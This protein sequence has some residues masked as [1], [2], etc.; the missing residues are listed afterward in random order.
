LEWLLFPFIVTE[1][2]AE[3]SSLW[4]FGAGGTPFQALLAFRI[5]TEK[6]GA[7]LLG[8]HLCVPW[9]ISHVDFNILGLFCTFIVLIICQGEFPFWYSLFGVLYASCTLI[10]IS[11]FRE[12]FMILLKIFSV[13]STWVS[14]FSHIPIDVR[15]GILTEFQISWM[16]CI[17]KFLEL[18]FSLI[19]V[20]SFSVVSSESVILFSIPMFC[21]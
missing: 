2:F 11:F 1:S 3:Y 5:P 10:G 21:C 4:S 14:S 6:S 13:F 7:V 18:T 20:S 16:F 8:V 12:S 15:F 17:R 19:K 9:H